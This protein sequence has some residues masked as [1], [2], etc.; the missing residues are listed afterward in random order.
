MQPS[1]MLPFRIASL[2]FRSKRDTRV[3]ERVPG[4][5]VEED[6]PC[7]GLPPPPPPVA[8]Q[9][10]LLTA[11]AGSFNTA[12]GSPHGGGERLY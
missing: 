1:M 10:A 4:V 11:S 8:L 9:G 7:D 12:A 3:L 6:R 2:S 5:L